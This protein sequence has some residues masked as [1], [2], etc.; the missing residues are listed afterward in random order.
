MAIVLLLSPLAPKGAAAAKRRYKQQK[1]KDKEKSKSLKSCN[2]AFC[3]LGD[4]VH[5]LK[6]ARPDTP[7]ENKGAP[8]APRKAAPTEMAL[9]SKPQTAGG[10][11]PRDG[12]SQ[13]KNGTTTRTERKHAGTPD[14]RSHR[15][16]EP[17]LREPA[18][19]GP[20]S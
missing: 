1:Q 19:L 2:F 12:G 15:G 10:T 6:L 3:S 17:Q 4:S 13:A 16:P 14:L 5:A 8:L 11:V 18:Y 20:P 9:G 7:Q